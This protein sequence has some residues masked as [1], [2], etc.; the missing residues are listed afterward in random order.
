MNEKEF[1]RRVS[2]LLDPERLRTK[3]VAVIGLGSGGCRVAAEL[4]RL[5]VQLLLIERPGERIEEHN[6][7]RH[8]LGYRSLGK[9]KLDEMS[10]YIRNLNPSVRIETAGLDV[11]QQQ[12]A[13]RRSLTHWAPDL[14]AVCTDNE[15]SKHA[16]D[17]VAVHQKIS[18]TG[19]AVYDGGIGGEVYRVRPGDA[20]YGCLAA[21]LKLERQA[22]SLNA[23]R[24][25]SSR[26]DSPTTSALNLDIEQIALL[27]C[28]LALEFLLD[29]EPRRVRLPP[30]VNLCVFAN[31]MVPGLFS[32]PWHG[33][34]F[35]IPRRPDCLNCGVVPGEV[36]SES[37]R[38]LSNLRESSAHQPR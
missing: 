17:Q 8:L 30:E 33:Q 27:Q 5:G 21:H 6:L 20:C 31:Y 12:P 34:F 9:S 25:Y 26:P 10:H 24:D 14:I 23:A 19:G 7:I 18:Q 22:P 36:E 1:Y 37:A 4:G 32:R 38:I 15:P 29:T 28:R 3:R 35:S 2:A 13:L 16:I 11:V